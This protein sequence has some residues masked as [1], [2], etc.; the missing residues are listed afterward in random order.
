M[1]LALFPLLALNIVWGHNLMLGLASGGFYFFFLTKL[2]QRKIRAGFAE[3]L[4]FLLASL[5]LL[6]GLIYYFFSL[7]NPFLLGALFLFNV[8]L[9]FAPAASQEKIALTKRPALAWQSFK[10]RVKNLPS[11]L[12]PNLAS[13]AAPLFLL[14]LILLTTAL[15]S[16]RTAQA[17]RSPW[18]K[19]PANFFPFYFLLS[20]FLLII[21]LRS[22][23]K[24]KIIFLWLYYFFS[25]SALLIVYRLG[26]G[27]DGFL[28]IAAEKAIW[29]KGVILPKTIYYL[30][31]YALV[32]F[33]A[34]IF[35]LPVSLV[36]KFLTPFFFAFFVPYFWLKNGEK[37]FP[38]ERKNVT[39][40][41]AALLLLFPYSSFTF[42]TPQNLA[43]AFFLIFLSF[44]LPH[45][46][47]E[48]CPPNLLL[49][50]FLSATIFIIHPLSGI[51][52]FLASGFFVLQKIKPK[53][54]PRL[55][56]ASLILYFFCWALALPLAFWLSAYLL[57]L[58][59]AWRWPALLSWIKT[60]GGLKI[61]FVNNFHYFLNFVY[62]YAFNFYLWC[63]LAAA[64]LGLIFWPP[65]KR[66]FYF[67]AFS[68]TF[69]S[70]FILKMFFS[71]RFL[72]N[73]EQ[74]DYA[75]RAREIAFYFLYPLLLFGLLAIQ[76]KIQKKSRLALLG[77]LCFLAAWLTASF[78]LSYPRQDSY[79]TSHAFNTTASDFQSVQW[80][81]RQNLNKKYL[82]LA[83]QQVAA[84]A[85]EKYGF[86]PYY[87]EQFY[88][89]L[90]A[91]SFL[92]QEYLKMLHHPS[93]Q[94]LLKIKK[95]FS[96]YHIQHVYLILNSYWW[97]AP[98]IKKKI[99]PL[100][101][102]VWQIKNNTIFF[103]DLTK[104]NP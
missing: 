103:F 78:Y 45:C 80:L 75:A 21:L 99:A 16:H 41:F 31:Q 84:A 20:F 63:F 58:N 100:A 88:Y 18:T 9:L 65:R 38:P 48:N 29:Q 87:G 53:L 14:L 46:E 15:L 96:R 47:K 7:S 5:T 6:G 60:A 3:A 85:I 82:V 98:A 56:K 19:M 104:I 81:Y 52:A 97:N 79:F 13:L 50:F 62:F 74:G 1:S 11:P 39:Y 24:E 69:L 36:D 57:K 72:V 93:R 17:L 86:Q 95:R 43:N 32:I 77:F 4:F 2:M 64:A 76:E 101:Q 73:Y 44:L 49:L 30:G 33:L 92:Y 8:A 61:Y 94:E 51:F 83:D 59:I 28:H 12:S 27:F 71:F 23:L 25:V 68:A 22:Q 37:I 91:S 10:Q 26:Y 54:P 42:S 40:L 55:F 34:K 67:Y 70:F 35:W 90:P 102:K 66:F 89:S